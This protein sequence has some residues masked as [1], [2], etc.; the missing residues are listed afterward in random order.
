[1]KGI[2]HPYFIFSNASLNLVG[3]SLVIKMLKDH[4]KQFNKNEFQ[5]NGLIFLYNKLILLMLKS[6]KSLSPTA[7][8]HHGP[9]PAIVELSLW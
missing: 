7:T 6:D 3:W 9:P 2:S 1:M 4:F 8:K 5:L